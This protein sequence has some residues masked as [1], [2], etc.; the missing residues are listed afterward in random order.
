MKFNFLE[1]HGLYP[2]YS[3]QLKLINFTQ[4]F[5]DSNYVENSDINEIIAVVSVAE[6]V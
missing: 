3:F 2:T 4:L 6:T 5:M 1:G